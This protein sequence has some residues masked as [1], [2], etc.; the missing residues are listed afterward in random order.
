M[1]RSLQTSESCPSLVRSRLTPPTST[2]SVVESMK[3]V[4]EKS[5]TTSF[6]PL[7][8]T[9]SSCCLNS[10]AVLRSTSPE[11][12][13]TYASS[14]SCS[15]VMSKFIGRGSLTLRLREG[16]FELTERL[17]DR[18]GVG[19]VGRDLEE[20]PVG[21]DRGGHV[22]RALGGRGPLQQRVRL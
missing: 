13:I 22:V 20:L 11:S 9:S 18:G 8:I 12:E 16:R 19:V 21:S 6:A 17:P 7:P 15:V 2:P 3:V 14:E 4:L 1:L 5:T 10:G